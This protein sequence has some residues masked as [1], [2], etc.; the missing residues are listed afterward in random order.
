LHAPAAVGKL[1]RFCVKPWTR[2]DRKPSR[3]PERDHSPLRR[4]SPPA[5]SKGRRRGG[6]GQK[7]EACRADASQRRAGRAQDARAGRTDPAR[8]RM[9]RPD[10]ADRRGG[11]ARS[12]IS[13]LQ[14]PDA[15]RPG[16]YR[17]ARGALFR[18][19]RALLARER[20]E[21]A[22]KYARRHRRDLRHCALR[23]RH[24]ALRAR[25]CVRALRPEAVQIALAGAS[26][27]CG[28]SRPR[29][30][31]HQSFGPSAEQSGRRARQDRDHGVQ[32]QGRPKRPQQ[33]LF[34]HARCARTR[35]R[36]DL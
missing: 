33:N 2:S 7:P 35:R 25:R 6:R 15:R 27:R 24:R 20:G 4:Q 18:R 30:H 32:G 36:E 21:R 23:P 34:R 3:R 12:S 1:L 22:G 16:L 14:N 26:P 5:R 11:P 31:H 10:G 29:Q 19:G 13:R 9:D 28:R 8:R 17:A